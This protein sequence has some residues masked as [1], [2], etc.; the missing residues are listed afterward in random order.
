MGDRNSNSRRV[1]LPGDLL[2]RVERRLPHTQ[3]ETPDSYITNVLE[4]V[5]F[6][7]EEEM[8]DEGV[9]P[10]D[11]AEVADRLRSLGY[12]EE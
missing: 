2:Q 12:L 6:R 7:V 5:L 11:E 1:E 10:V 8:A 3:W 9:E 4:E